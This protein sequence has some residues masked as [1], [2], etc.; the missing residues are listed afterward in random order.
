MQTCNYLILNYSI[1][2]NMLLHIVTALTLT[3]IGWV[4]HYRRLDSWG[5]SF[6]LIASWQKWTRWM[7]L[8][9]GVRSV[10]RW[11][12]ALASNRQTRRGPR[13]EPTNV[14]GQWLRKLSW[15]QPCIEKLKKCYILKMNFSFN[16]MRS[17]LYLLAHNLSFYLLQ[18]NT[19]LDW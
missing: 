17:T 3:K 19:T 11:V 4:S 15:G 1:A 18:W 16:C 7:A 2:L 14:V 10:C 9:W 13:I 6:S 8:T 5:Q 12:N